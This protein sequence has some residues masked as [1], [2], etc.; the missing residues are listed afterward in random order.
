MRKKC[1]IALFSIVLNLTFSQPILENKS[2]NQ[3]DQV[4]E[5]II[6]IEP[7][8]TLT[9]G[10]FFT[11]LSLVANHPYV[12]KIKGFDFEWGYRYQLKVKET[13][14]AEVPSDAPD[15]SFELIKVILQYKD[16]NDFELTLL[17]E[18]Y[19]SEPKNESVIKI[20]SGL[21][22]YH[23]NLIF[24]VPPR[25]RAIFDRKMKQKK[26]CKGIFGYN[27]KGDIILKD[28]K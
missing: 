25:L 22:S 6:I 17:N 23:H 16:Q 10:A 19:L 1:L 21:Y 2:E 5:L 3:K 24:K 26:Y 27:I 20:K 4:N 11:D 15:R 28:L 12:E 13:I 14:F 18:F 9:N 7:Y 8:L